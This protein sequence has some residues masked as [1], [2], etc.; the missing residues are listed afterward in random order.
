MQK[1]AKTQVKSRGTAI[2]LFFTCQRQEYIL[3]TNSSILVIIP[4]ILIFKLDKIDIIHISLN[5]QSVP[6]LV[7]VESNFLLL[8][9][10]EYDSSPLIMLC[11]NSNPMTGDYFRPVSVCD[12]LS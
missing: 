9:L 5:R 1:I 8:H 10:C 3:K 6:V 7:L 4:S 11:S 12:S 2:F